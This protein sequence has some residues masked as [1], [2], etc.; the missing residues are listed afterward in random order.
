MIAGNPRYPTPDPLRELGKRVWTLPEIVLSK[1]D[2]VSVAYSTGGLNDEPIDISLKT[3]PKNQL[4]S[5]AWDDALC[6]RQLLEHYSSLHLSRL[7]L[8]KIILECLMS[9][10]F[11]ELNPG[12]RTYAMMGLLRIRP[13]INRDDSPF[14]AFA[15]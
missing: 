14:Q 15:R 13:P 4:P 12:D 10:E 1:G 5:I 6:S 2:Y 3:I 8:V 9:R 7:E 11:K